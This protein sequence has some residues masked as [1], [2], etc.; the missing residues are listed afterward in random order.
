MTEHLTVEVLDNIRDNAVA[1]KKL[2]LPGDKVGILVPKGMSLETH[3]PRWPTLQRVSAARTFYDR[4]SF[5]DYVKTFSDDRTR[6]FALPAHL[7]GGREA[8][9]TAIFD[10]HLP[11]KPEYGA[12]TAKLVLQFSEEWRAWTAAASNKFTQ[13]EFAEWIE[14]RRRD[15]A[16]PSAAEMLDLV[17]NFKA[18]R[19][20]QFDSVAY[21]ENGDIRLTYDEDTQASAKST[22]MAVPASLK[23]G[24]P[25]YFNGELFEVGVLLRYRLGAGSVSF[26]IKLDRPDYVETAA[27]DRI[28]AEI[29]EATDHTALIGR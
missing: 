2:E 9:V 26:E 18:S 11:S 14:E 13:H 16:S 10:D 15:I 5:C 23:L 3:E 1:G 21:Q 8:T 6:L 17:R 20:V 12:H 22:G 4:A 24:I 28:L 7:S 25:V 19:K 27:F 29:R